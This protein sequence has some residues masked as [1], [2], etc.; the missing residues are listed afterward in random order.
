MDTTTLIVVLVLVAAA[1]VLWLYIARRRAHLKSQFGPEYDRMA[2]ER[3]P[4]RADAVLAEREQRVK[5]YEIRPLTPELSR[6]FTDAWQRVQATFV[7][8]PAAAVTDAD[9]L[10]T[11]VMNA[12][13]YPMSDFDRR[14]DDLSVDHAN[15]IHHYRKAHDIAVRHS[16]QGASTE[17]LR[18]AVVHYRALFEDLLE[19]YEPERKRA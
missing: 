9:Q 5:R 4:G 15:V 11:E 10:V 14:T 6:Q 12:R 3:G 17:E 2:S 13:G 19:V 8:D 16:N 1:V 7:D 18:Q